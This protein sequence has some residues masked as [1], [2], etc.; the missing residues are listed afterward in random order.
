MGNASKPIVLTPLKF[1]EAVPGF[2]KEAVTRI[3]PVCWFISRSSCPDRRRAA[4][5]GEARYQSIHHKEQF[6]DENGVVLVQQSED[7][8]LLLSLFAAP[9][10]LK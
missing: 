9:Q 8:I 10:A 5:W 1:E 6:R 4:S 3:A 2:G 7:A